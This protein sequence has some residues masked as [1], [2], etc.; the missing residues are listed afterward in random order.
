MLRR[1]N[2]PNQVVVVEWAP[3]LEAEKHGSVD[4]GQAV[5]AARDAKDIVLE[6]DADDFAEADGDDGQVVAPQ[7]KDGADEE[8]SH[9]AGGD[10]P[11][12]QKCQNRD[13]VVQVQDGGGVGA[14]AVERGVA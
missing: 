4:A 14:D 7:M 12:G 1:T 11:D 9:Q 5:R 6:G 2:D 10:R 8:E 13:L 3:E